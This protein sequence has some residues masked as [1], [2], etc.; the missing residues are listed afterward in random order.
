MDVNFVLAI[1]TF[2]YFYNWN[3]ALNSV[4]VVTVVSTSSLLLQVVQQWKTG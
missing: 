2:F 4:K 3:W 1:V